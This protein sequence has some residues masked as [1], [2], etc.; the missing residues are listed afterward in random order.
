MCLSESFIS[1]T[2]VNSDLMPSHKEVSD[3]AI[4]YPKPIY[5]RFWYMVEYLYGKA[6]LIMNNLFFYSLDSS[7]PN[8]M[9]M[10]EGR[11]LKICPFLA[12]FCPFLQLGSVTQTALWETCCI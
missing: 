6:G 4:I 5:V 7:F 12:K 9:S 11:D 10:E 1:R 2:I 8:L 3:L